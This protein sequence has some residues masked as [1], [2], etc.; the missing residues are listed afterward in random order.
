M[1]KIKCAFCGQEIEGTKYKTISRKHYHYECYNKMVEA[2]KEADKNKQA[3]SFDKSYT[4]LVKYILQLYGLKELPPNIC[5]QINDFIDKNGY[6]Y[7]GILETLL[8]FHKILNKPPFDRPTI[9]IVLWYYEEAKQFYK[10]MEEIN[11][12]NQDRDIT[13]NVVITNIKEPNYKMKTINIDDL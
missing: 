7:Y 11:K 5:N 13:S 6:T 12:A 1:R 9:G 2:A 8:Y 4:N 3:A 10:N